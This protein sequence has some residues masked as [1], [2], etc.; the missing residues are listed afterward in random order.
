MDTLAICFFP[1]LFAPVIAVLIISMINANKTRLKA[2][3]KFATEA[4][5]NIIYGNFFSMP[6]VTGKYKGFDYV[7]EI[8]T[9]G[10]GESSTT[11]TLM[12]MNVPGPPGYNLQV[13]PEGL[14]SKVGKMLGAQDIQIG[15][16]AFDDTFM[17]KSKTPDKIDKLLTRDVQRKMLYGPHLINISLSGNKLVNKIPNV[18]T[19]PQDLLYLTDLMYDLT[20]NI[21]GKQIAS[22]KYDKK[23]YEKDQKLLKTRLPQSILPKQNDFT[24]DFTSDFTDNKSHTP[25]REEKL[26]PSCGA[27]SP[28]ENRYCTDC[29]REI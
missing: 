10:D 7:L 24:S 1:L 3:E 2:W 13:Y 11:Y 6:K 18:I 5:L 26:C 17:I 15:N 28:A 29:G 16:K 20:V 22:E 4:G 12:T 14:L 9:E 19:E 8:I 27:S 23:P 21:C 25:L